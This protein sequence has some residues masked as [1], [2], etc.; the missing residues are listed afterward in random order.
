LKTG[1]RQLGRK[2][3]DGGEKNRGK[4]PNK[5]ITGLRRKGQLVV[6]FSVARIAKGI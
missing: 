4:R 3:K 2:N 1:H 5:V 6:K